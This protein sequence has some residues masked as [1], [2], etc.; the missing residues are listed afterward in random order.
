MGPT[1]FLIS[2]IL[3]AR[4]RVA[5][6][7]LVDLAEGKIALLLVTFGTGFPAVWTV[8]HLELFWRS[9]IP[10]LEAML[11]EKKSTVM[12]QRKIIGSE[13]DRVCIYING[14]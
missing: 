3:P 13:R 4:P 8:F 11:L 12:A 10:A 14:S 5:I 1:R 2:E 6:V 9:G 7:V